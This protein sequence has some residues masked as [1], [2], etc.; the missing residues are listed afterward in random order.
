MLHIAYKVLIYEYLENITNNLRY[1]TNYEWW[2]AIAFQ[3]LIGFIY[4]IKCSL[5]IDEMKK[6][7]TDIYFLI[8][9]VDSN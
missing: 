6:S 2:I 3:T 7:K 8:I 4:I 5:V 9:L 1:Q